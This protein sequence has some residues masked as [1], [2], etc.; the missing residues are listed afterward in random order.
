MS[1]SDK[2]P[3]SYRRISTLKAL[4]GSGEDLPGPLR[5]LRQY[6]FVLSLILIALTALA[7]INAYFH[8]ANITS[9]DIDRTGSTSPFLLAGYVGMFITVAFLPIP[10]TSSFRPMDI[11]PLLGF[12]ILIQHSLYAF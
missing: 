10:T 5:K 2:T 9:Y 1:E 12:L 8:I 3:G 6:I 7:L 4:L 11:S